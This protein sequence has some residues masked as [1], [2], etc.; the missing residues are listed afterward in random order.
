MRI[1][2][3]LL[4]A[5]AAVTVLGFAIPKGQPEGVYNH[6]VVNGTD[7]HKKIAEPYLGPITKRAPRILSMEGQPAKVYCGRALNLNHED[8]D[9]ANADLD[10]QC[11]S[12][13]LIGGGYNFYAIRGGT[14]AFVC[15]FGYFYDHHR[16]YE[17]K[18]VKSSKVITEFCGPYN[19]GWINYE[20]GWMSYGYD[21]TASDFC[22][23]GI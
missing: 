15:N 10:R 20:Y 1:K 16:C 12:G 19:S 13:A 7:I 4:I 21:T 18:R 9:A 8:T 6:T 5:T 14:A 23:T 2:S 11:G 17:D 3:I 22:G